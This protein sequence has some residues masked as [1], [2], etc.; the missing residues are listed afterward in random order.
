M[1]I[2]FTHFVEAG[3]H[4][5]M[6]SSFKNH[7]NDVFDSHSQFFLPVIRNYVPRLDPSNHKGVCGRIGIIGG[8]K[9]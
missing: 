3:L 9:E 5:S 7:A 8:C 2:M 1:R 6:A 4:Y